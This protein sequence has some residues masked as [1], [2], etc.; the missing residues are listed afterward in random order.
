[1]YNVTKKERRMPRKLVQRKLVMKGINRSS[2]MLWKRENRGIDK[3]VRKI[4]IARTLAG[5]E[6]NKIGNMEI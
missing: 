1:M 4:Q 5:M 6:T 3:I 2:S